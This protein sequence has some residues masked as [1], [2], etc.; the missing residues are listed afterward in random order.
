MDKVRVGI[1]GAA[2]YTGGELI[3]ILL[4][5]PQA[6]LVW[7]QS[8]SQPGAPIWHAHPD[9]QGYT[10]LTFCQT[11]SWDIDVLFMCLGHGVSQK[12]LA[13]NNPPKSV[14]IIDLSTDFRPETNGFVY[15]LPEL[16]REAI[17]VA[18]KVANP[19]CFAT[20]II[21][22]L[23]PFAHAGILPTEIN[24]S[25]ITG[26]TGAGRSL[27][28]ALH[29][30]HRH[31]DV[32]VYKAF[33][34]QHIT[35][36]GMALMQAG[37]V[38]LPKIWFVPHRGNYTRGILTTAWFTFTGTET[39]A[40]NLFTHYY[41]QHPFVLLADGMP[42]VK[43]TVNTNMFKAG[44]EVHDGKIA[45]SGAIDNLL[46]GASGQAVQNMNLMFGFPETQGLMLK[47]VAF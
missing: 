26:S 17:K 13:E 37:A 33:K 22:S 46:K 28:D 2:G 10:N 4:A 35:E 15:G 27:T 43:Q 12:Y 3:R 18:R 44:I 29:F 6:E 41:H 42:G 9:L 8:T 7:A 20:S 14:A 32:S 45:V 31:A 36:V 38:Q 21:L 1:A 30:T 11:P 34:H 39:D 19:G 23:L 16:K 40:K 47:A 24:I 25:G 5:H